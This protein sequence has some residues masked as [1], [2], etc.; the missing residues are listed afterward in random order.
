MGRGLAWEVS[1][2]IPQHANPRR[3]LFS[4]L[5]GRTSGSTPSFA[6]V[7]YFWPVAREWGAL[8]RVEHQGAFVVEADFLWDPVGG[9][10]VFRENR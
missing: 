4:P 7:Y 8:G 10:N 1:T 2:C 5:S 3:A 6:A 9:D